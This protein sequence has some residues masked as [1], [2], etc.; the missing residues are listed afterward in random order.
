MKQIMTYLSTVSRSSKQDTFE[1]RREIAASHSHR[2]MFLTEI[3]VILRQL[4][5]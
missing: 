5:I 3:R 4:W 1:G 2:L